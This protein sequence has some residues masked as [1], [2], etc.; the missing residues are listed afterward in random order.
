VEYSKIAAQTSDIQD[1]LTLFTATEQAYRESQ[2]KFDAATAALEVA[3]GT[4]EEAEARELLSQ[5]LDQRDQT[6]SDWDKL[7]EKNRP[8]THC[9]LD[10][11]AILGVASA[12]IPWPDHNQ[13]PRNTYQTQMGKQAL[14]VYHVNHGNRFDGTTKILAFPNRPIVETEIQSL[15][16]LNNRGP[17][18]MVTV[19]FA[20]WPYTEEDSFVFK[21]EFLDNGGFRIIKHLTCKA[22]V[23]LSGTVVESLGRP[24]PRAGEPDG[25]YRYIQQ[26]EPGNP[27]N[28]LPMIGA[29]LRQGD[30]VIGKIQKVTATGEVID[31]SVILRVGEEGIVEKVSVTSNNLTINVSVKLRRSRVPQAGDKFAPRNAQKGTIGEV[32]SDIDMPVTESGIVPDIIVNTAQIPSRMTME[33]LIEVLASLHGAYRCKRVNGTAFRP[34]MMEDYRETLRHYGLHEYGY[35]TMRSGSSGLKTQ[36]LMFCGPVLF[37]AL[38]HHVL[39]KAQARSIGKVKPMT[40]QPPKGRGVVGGLRFGVMERDVVIST[41]C[42][43]FL[44]ER[45]MTLSDGY[46]AAFC[47]R[48]GFF[49][50]ND[51]AGG[52]RPCR[53]CNPDDRL[54]AMWGRCTIPYAYKLLIHL[55]ATMGINLH[56]NFLYYREYASQIL[57]GIQDGTVTA[58]DLA[59]LS[60][61]ARE[62]EERED[63]AHD[64]EVDMGEV[65]DD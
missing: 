39:D 61:L 20:N 18:E 19:M 46:Q 41:G 26:Y 35:H 24:E 11:Q 31:D 42:S 25:R 40:R 10:P 3:M 36:A 9:E 51:A 49:A 58:D 48:C 43:A 17:G 13:A 7:R 32:A 56:P 63:Q 5:A 30:C 52:Y 27:N 50:V 12:L 33:Y 55:L 22:T 28:G 53:K 23:K 1:R 44:R 37:Q 6:K 29:Y 59:E 64:L 15:I 34:V 2:A 45:L 38:R 4:E 54:P 21:R 57:Q 60:E 62:E 47:K 8:Y 65:F 14:G 16:G